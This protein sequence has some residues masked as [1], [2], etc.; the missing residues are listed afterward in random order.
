MNGLEMIKTNSFAEEGVTKLSLRRDF[1]KQLDQIMPCTVHQHCQ[2]RQKSSSTST[3]LNSTL[4]PITN[5]TLEC[6][7]LK[8]ES[9]ALAQ[10]QT[11][12]PNTQ[13]RNGIIYIARCTSIY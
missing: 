7:I 2:T 5:R 13:R 8:G 3:N 11:Y 9:T 1:A 10:K 4:S 6:P 12:P